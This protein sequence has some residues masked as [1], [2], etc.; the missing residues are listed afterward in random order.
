MQESELVAALDEIK[1]SENFRT[2]MKNGLS[3]A[4]R[5]NWVTYVAAFAASLLLVTLAA[6]HF[7]APVTPN[8]FKI[9]GTSSEAGCY[10][11]IVYID[12]YAYYSSEWHHDKPSSLTKGDKLGEVSLDLK[13]LR[14]TGIPPNFSS[15]LNVGTEI[16]TIQGLKPE[17]AVL[18]VGG[19]H[20][21]ILYRQ[22][23]VQGDN[24]EQLGLSVAEVV[25]M[26]TID[27][28]LVAVDLLEE[29]YESLIRTTSNQDLLFL[30]ERDLL[31]QSILPDSA[32]YESRIPV[33]LIFKGGEA[34]HLQV[35]PEL[36]V[37][38]VFGGNIQLSPELV[39]AFKALAASGAQFPS[40]ADLLPYSE[41]QIGYLHYTNHQSGD[42]ITA[43]EESL[44]RGPLY[45]LFRYCRLDPAQP[46]SN[47]E[48]VMTI[49]LGR[50][51]Q[52]YI[53]LNIYDSGGS[54][55]V[56]LQGE[57]YKLVKGRFD[58]IEEIENAFKNY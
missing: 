47:R 41:E 2:R 49:E 22:N 38:Y 19:M 4:P 40:L 35:Y 1:V 32:I 46:E 21:F 37:A 24:R 18:A 58:V 39:S 23:K 7:S 30:I 27:S 15:T 17:Y 51:E 45:E 57:Y 33:N 5:R 48:L 3:A 29:E 28:A 42:K 20:Q 56:E 54:L 50:T 34:L 10:A 55:L 43:G 6:L 44:T 36:G 25:S 16:Y 14:Y 31:G 11:M 9:I 53:P 13:G 8:A 12:G 52:D 26:I